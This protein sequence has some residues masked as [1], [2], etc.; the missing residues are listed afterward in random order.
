M[1]ESLCTKNVS[2]LAIWSQCRAKGETFLSAATG[3]WVAQWAQWAQWA[4]LWPHTLKA[5]GS[6]PVVFALC[7]GGVSPAA[8]EHVAWRTGVSKLLSPCLYLVLKWL[9]GTGS[10][11]S[12][13][14]CWVSGY[15][16]RTDVETFTTTCTFCPPNK[17]PRWSGPFFQA[18]SAK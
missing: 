17:A 8:L 7:L 16:R 11:L 10:K 12:A 2:I 18:T 3:L 14:L 9:P 4:V 15:E 5:G 6:V 13:T 1:H